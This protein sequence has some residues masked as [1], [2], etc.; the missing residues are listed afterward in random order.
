MHKKAS[1]IYNQ[2][3]K[4]IHRALH[5]IG[6]PYKENRSELVTLFGEIAGRKVTGLSDLTLGERNQV[7]RHFQKKGLRLY[8]PM[9]LKDLMTWRKGDADMDNKKS[10]RPLAVPA[11]KVRL[12]NKIWAILTDLDLTWEY[13][14]GVSRKMFGI[15]VVE[16]C[17]PE[18][19]H[20]IVTAMVIHQ[21]RRLA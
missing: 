15:R 17:T 6:M 21:K 1:D 3:N 14:D 12:V 5:D 8:K 2:Q 10:A 4:T 18:Q 13:A 16:W 7:I 11:A 9:V 19:L 20:K